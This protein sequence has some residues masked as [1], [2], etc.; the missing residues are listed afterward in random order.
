MVGGGRRDYCWT[1]RP[2]WVLNPGAG[3]VIVVVGTVVAT[4]GLGLHFG[5]LLGD[6]LF[7][8][9][10]DESMLPALPPKYLGGLL[11]PWHDPYDPY[12]SCPV[13]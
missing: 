11:P 1:R 2:D 10:T 6:W 12:A 9:P 5:E 13:Y 7:P 3:F 4:I 8:F